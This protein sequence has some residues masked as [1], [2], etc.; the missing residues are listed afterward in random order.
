MLC[1]NEWTYAGGCG[2]SFARSAETI[3]TASAPSVSRQLSKRH[4]GSEIQRAS[5]YCSRVSGLSCIV[6]A[7]LRLAC[8]RNATATLA[9]CSRVAPYSCMY[10]RVSIAISSTG[11]MTPKG[12]L[13]CQ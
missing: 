6:A 11:R 4:S 1:A 3:T 9:R 12:R 2:R 5:M 13:H 8:F 7:G 10:R